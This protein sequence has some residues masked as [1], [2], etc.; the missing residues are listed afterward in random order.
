MLLHGLF[1]SGGNLGAL[2]RHL[3]E[4]FQVLS[5]DLPGH[6]R[7]AWLPR[8]SL[9]EFAA[10]IADWLRA[11]GVYKAHFVGHSLGGKVAMEL[12][13][14]FPELV[15]SLVVADIAPATYGDRHNPVFAALGAVAAAHCESRADAEAIM[16]Q[17]LEEAAVI[18]FLLGS[19]RRDD[20]GVYRWQ[21]DREGL[22]RDYPALR[23]APTGNTAWPGPVLFVKGE[24]SDYITDKHRG[25]IEALFP[26]ADL[27]IM[28]G[29]GHWLHAEKPELFN[30]IVARFLEAGAGA[31]DLAGTR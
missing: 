17:H 12:A 25:A 21:M 29:C 4:A 16:A 10:V 14:A 1:G 5:L 20:A 26:Q 27:K 19:L 6:G 15:R 2:A 28:R 13:L 9:A 7:S 24:H 18:Q 31:A 22:Q 3:R 23:A 11:Q 30:S 8:Y